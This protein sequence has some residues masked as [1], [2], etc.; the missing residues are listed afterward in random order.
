MDLKFPLRQVNLKKIKYNNQILITTQ[1][2]SLT[3]DDLENDLT[4]KAL[5]IKPKTKQA[6]GRVNFSCILT[7]SSRFLCIARFLISSSAFRA[8]FNVISLASEGTL[9]SG[10]P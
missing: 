3:F 10:P 9:K 6:A 8:C 5:P 2:K 1:A 7:H 4:P